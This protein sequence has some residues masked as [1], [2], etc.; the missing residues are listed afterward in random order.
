MKTGWIE[1][2]SVDNTS[3]NKLG[4]LYVYI[5]KRCHVSNRRRRECYANI[6]VLI[7]KILIKNI[8]FLYC[9]LSFICTIVVLDLVRGST[10][11]LRIV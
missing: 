4:G 9:R 5:S 2:N 7:I 3:L 8:V 10:V 6:R 11:H 1:K